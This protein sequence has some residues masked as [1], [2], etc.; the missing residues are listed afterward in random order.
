MQ[1]L[2]SWFS[3]HQSLVIEVFIVVLIALLA[4]AALQRLLKRLSSRLQK[5]ET[6]WDE[7]LTE[8]ASKPIAWCVAI[9]GISFAVEVLERNNDYASLLAQLDQARNISLL[10]L[11][12]WFLIRFI[13]RAEVILIDRHYDQTTVIAIARLLRATV[14]ITFAL[15]LLQAMGYSVGGVMAFGGIGG[16]AVGFAAQDLLANFF[17]GLMIYLDRPFSVGDWIRSPDRS[18][19]GTVENIGWRLT[20]IRTFDKRPLYVPNAVFTKIAIENPSRM[21]NRR[22]YETLGLRY[23]DSAAISAIVKDVKA[24][25]IAHDAIDSEQT[26]I[27]NFNGLGNSSLDFFIY[28]FTKTTDWV[29]FHDIKQ[30][31][32]L[33]VMAVIE[34]HDAELAFP[35]STVQ[36]QDQNAAAK[37]MNQD[38]NIGTTC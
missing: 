5:T 17:G 8:A 7:A 34:S 14:F 27:V 22:I 23:A 6:P 24:M 4:N 1:D 3:T 18:I 11:I 21:S 31:V 15:V 2:S 28:T 38:K 13:H 30:D 33:K 16:I 19:E 25:L 29:E 12:G 9:Y 20:L 26:L 36:I 10:A 35:T 32:L 37:A